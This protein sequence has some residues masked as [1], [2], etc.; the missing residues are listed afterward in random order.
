MQPQG[1]HTVRRRA[2][3]S[4]G[5][6]QLP[7]RG[8]QRE[9]QALV[10]I[11]LYGAYTASKLPEDTWGQA[12]VRLSP[13]DVRS[14]VCGRPCPGTQDPENLPRIFRLHRRGRRIRTCGPGAGLEGPLRRCHSRLPHAG[15]ERPGTG[16]CAA[17]AVPHSAP[18]RA[19]R[20][21]TRVAAGAPRPGQRLRRQGLS[22][23]SLVTESCASA[24][25]RPGAQR[26]GMRTATNCLPSHKSR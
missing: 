20:L 11:L 1:R 23:R 8:R 22:S 5:R 17:A 6:G 19:I 7:V 18:D 4:A 21:R 25:W 16:A 2:Q 10:L 3:S 9:Q 12:P 24:R 13:A 14:P 26:R 15:D